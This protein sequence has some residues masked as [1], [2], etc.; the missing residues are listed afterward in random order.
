MAT[1][2]RATR[3]GTDAARHAAAY[4]TANALAAA[5]PPRGMA[6]FRPATAGAVPHG[7]GLTAAAEAAAARLAAHAAAEHDRTGEIH[8]PAPQHPPP[9]EAPVVHPT[10]DGNAPRIHITPG[11]FPN[12]TGRNR[13]TLTFNTDPKQ[14]GVWD[15]DPTT[16]V[17]MVSGGSTDRVADAQS[18]ARLAEGVLNLPDGHVR[19]GAAHAANPQLPPPN[20]FGINGVPAGLGVFLIEQHVLS[21]TGLTTFIT[22]LDPPLEG[23]MGTVEGLTYPN[24]AAGAQEAAAAV[25]DTMSR[26]PNFVQLILS[27]RDALPPAWTVQQVL[28]HVLSS[29]AVVPIELD[30]GRGTVRVAW[31]VFMAVTTHRIASFNAIRS[32]FAQLLFITTWNNTGRVRADMACRICPS[33]DHP[34]GLCPFPLVPGWMGH[35]PTTLPPPATS[36]EQPNNARGGGGR[37]GNANA[38]TRGRARGFGGRGFTPRGGFY[39]ARGGRF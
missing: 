5:A 13:E 33:I 21:T 24:T 4:A 11:P 29:V 2:A 31:R 8:A 22:T 35:T 12:V 6:Q 23:F 19:A 39:N 9:Q 20:L 26:T 37:G 32:S 34:T 14:I 3:A 18:I 7:A 1:Q 10:A 27:H 25:V 15:S 28:D 16:L 17:A 36:T 38:R 30:S